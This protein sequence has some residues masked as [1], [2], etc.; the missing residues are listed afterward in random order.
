MSGLKGVVENVVVKVFNGYGHQHDLILYGQV[1]YGAR[2]KERAYTFSVLRDIYSIAKLYFVKPVRSAKVRM[3]WNDQVVNGTTDDEGFFKLEWSSIQSTPAGWLPVRIYAVDRY[4]NDI[5]FGDGKVFIP[6]ITQYG[7]IS[8]IDDTVLVSHSARTGKKLTTLLTTD[9]LKRKTFSDVVR[10]YQMLGLSHTEPNVPNPFFYVSNSEWNLYDYLAGFF[11]QNKLPDGIFLLSDFKRLSQILKI[12][13]TKHRGK[14]ERMKRILEVFPNQ[15][16]ILVG[17]N[18][19]RD[20]LTYSE[21]ANEHPL[22]IEAI[23]IRI[24][25]EDKKATMIETLASIRHKN[26]HVHWFEDTNEAIAHA[27]TIGLITR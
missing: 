7:V 11:R 5:G 1:K 13:N 23:Y 17:D 18:S 25:R 12:G 20:P 24:V 26:I 2:K 8:D 10:F 22:R 16:F 9:P 19:Q 27:M 3:H 14:G 15:R 6:H 21:I 4:G